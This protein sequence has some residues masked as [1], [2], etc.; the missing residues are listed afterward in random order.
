MP[1]ELDLARGWFLKADSDLNTAKH[2]VESD[3]PY[4]TACFQAQQAAERY[5]KGLQ[6]LRGERFH[7]THDLEEREHLGGS[8]C[9]MAGCRIGPHRT[10]FL[11][12]SRY[13]TT[14]SSGP[15]ATNHTGSYRTGFGSA[16]SGAARRSSSRPALKNTHGQ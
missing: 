10:Q 7:R 1:D 5:L 15:T 8:A 13:G 11:T 12:Q 4:G 9:R 14:F 6:A 2:M 16:Q 3:G